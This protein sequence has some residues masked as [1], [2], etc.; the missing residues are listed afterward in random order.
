MRVILRKLWN[1]IKE[2]KALFLFQLED[3]IVLYAMPGDQAYFVARGKSHGFSRVASV[4]WD[5]FSHDG[6]HGASK[7]LYV[8]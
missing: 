8:L 7:V 3:G 4:T 2:L 1:S 5:V 6:G